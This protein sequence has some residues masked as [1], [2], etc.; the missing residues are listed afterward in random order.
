MSSPKSPRDWRVYLYV[1]LSIIAGV[2]V[3]ILTLWMAPYYADYVLPALANFLKLGEPGRSVTQALSSVTAF[4][5]GVSIALL[6]S[7]MAICL[8]DGK[9]IGQVS[10]PKSRRDWWVYLYVSLSIIAGAGVAIL[11]LRAV[12]YYAEYVLPDS[13]N[14][15]KSGEP[16]EPGRPGDDGSSVAQALSSVAAFIIGVPVALLGSLVAIYLAQKANQISGVVQ[17]I[18][19]R[20]EDREYIQ[21]LEE[22]YAKLIDPAQKVQQAY[23]DLL[24]AG[25]A[26]ARQ[27]VNDI[28]ESYQ[29]ETGYEYF[30]GVNGLSLTTDANGLPPASQEFQE[31]AYAFVVAAGAFDA[32][33]AH[34]IRWTDMSRAASSS[35][36]SCT[37]WA[38][39]G[40][41]FWAE[42]SGEF[43]YITRGA[44]L[45]Y[46][47]GP[48]FSYPIWG[49]LKDLRRDMPDV[50]RLVFICDAVVRHRIENERTILEAAQETVEAAVEWLMGVRKKYRMRWISRRS[51][52]EAFQELEARLFEIVGLFYLTGK[53]DREMRLVSEWGKQDLVK[54]VSDAMSKVH[55]EWFEHHEMPDDDHDE[56]ES[57]A[58]GPGRLLW[59]GLGAAGTW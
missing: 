50:R 40:N 27:F 20:R 9:A 54:P 6:G 21:L 7:L 17:D 11:M 13:A 41:E 18:E 51:Q 16:S 35:Q 52:E 4:I 25:R 12:P 32:A 56:L 39:E 10:S 36:A 58:P 14:F 31:A 3:A 49:A 34:W 55:A 47:P 15:L 30:P 33:V 26:V 57:P 2:G 46:I 48:F 37:P 45:S 44:S 42:R 28:P 19:K 53:Q 23:I 43:K 1:S 59:R 22:Q 5:I 38:Q 29:F 24:D 8:Q